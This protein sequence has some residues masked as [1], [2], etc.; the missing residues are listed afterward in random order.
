[1][2]RP[3]LFGQIRPYDLAR[4]GLDIANTKAFLHPLLADVERG[5]ICHGQPCTGDQL[6]SEDHPGVCN[7]EL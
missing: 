7:P 1:M 2:E 6:E 5:E 4:P 3:V